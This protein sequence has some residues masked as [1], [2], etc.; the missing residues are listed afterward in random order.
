MSDSA[1]RK[2]AQADAEK[3]DAAHA[4]TAHA[5]T[6]HADTAHAD[7]AHAEAERDAPAQAATDVGD[8]AGDGDGKP[9]MDEV[10]RKVREALDKKNETHTQGSVTRNTGKIHGAHGAEDH[11]R[12]FRR[13]SG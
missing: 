6:A 9:D 2:A 12:S 3:A 7:T 11:R 8:G 1:P 5:D 10:K 13:K 4:D